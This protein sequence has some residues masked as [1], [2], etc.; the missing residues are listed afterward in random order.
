MSKVPLIIIDSDTP[1]RSVDSGARVEPVIPTLIGD[2]GVQV[3]TVVDSGARVGPVVPIVIAD[4]GI[5]VDP[6]VSG[7]QAESKGSICES[8]WT[9]DLRILLVQAK[10]NIN[11]RMICNQV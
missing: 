2:S 9:R 11:H 3:V 10:K 4:S 5:R 7:E 8:Y 1:V 6:V